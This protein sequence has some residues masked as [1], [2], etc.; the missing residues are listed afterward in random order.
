MSKQSEVGLAASRG[1]E[2]GGGRAAGRAREDGAAR[3]GAAAVA[4]SA[5]PPLDC[6]IA[7]LGQAGLARRARRSRAQVAREQRRERGVD[8]GRRG[9]LVLAERA[10]DLVRQRDVD[11]RAARSRSA[12]PIARS[13]SGCA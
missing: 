6:M 3:R 5:R 7:R 10:D 13:C 12:A 1:D 9:A 11:V 2:R 8:L 4:A